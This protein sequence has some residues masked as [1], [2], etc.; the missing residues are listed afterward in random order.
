MTRVLNYV[1]IE[2]E[3]NDAPII[4]AYTRKEMKLLFAGL[5]DFN[6]SCKHLY[7]KRTKRSGMLAMLFNYIFVPGAKILPTFVMKNFGWHLVLTGVK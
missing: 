6:I 3:D 4:N 5:N 2:F 7:P 1:N